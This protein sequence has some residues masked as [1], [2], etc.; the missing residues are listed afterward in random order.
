MKRTNSLHS[1][2]V[3]AI[4]AAIIVIFTQITIPVGVVPFTL[5]TM[6]IALAGLLLKEREAM[7]AVGL[8]L[9]IG[10]VGLPVFAGGKAGFSVL[11]GPTGGFLIGFIL[12]AF[13]TAV[14]VKQLHKFNLNK[15]QSLFGQAGLAFVASALG[16]LIGVANMIFVVGLAPQV[17]FMSGMVLFLLP[18]AFKAVLAAVVSVSL[19]PALGH[20]NYFKSLAKSRS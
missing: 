9:L 6:G 18:E 7:L 15:F 20:L 13:L 4:F 17:A 2:I 11:F 10:F 5:Q 14:F 8:Y 19:V 12:Q 16:M 3:A 1:L